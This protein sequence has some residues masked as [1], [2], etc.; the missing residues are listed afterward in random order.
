[1]VEVCKILEVFKGIDEVK[2][3]KRSVE[4]TGGYDLKLYKT[5]VKL[6]VR[7]FKIGIRVCDE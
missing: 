3:F 6:H 1:M 5:L 7:K 2:L 4:C